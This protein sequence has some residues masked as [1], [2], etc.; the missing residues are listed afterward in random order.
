MDKSEVIA[1]AAKIYCELP[2]DTNITMDHM[3]KAQTMK[4]EEKIE[5]APHN[6]ARA[7][8]AFEKAKAFVA[9]ASKIK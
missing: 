2:N 5:T 6:I 1:L 4:R 9:V 8:V 7:L 3:D